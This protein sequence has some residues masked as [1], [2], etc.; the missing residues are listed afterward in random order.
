MSNVL[1]DLLGDRGV[2]VADG[3]MGTALFELGLESGGCPELLNVER[4]DLIEKVHDGYLEAGADIILTNTF[5]GNRPRLALHGLEDRVAELNEAAV[6]IARRAVSNSGRKAV[7]AGSVGPTGE[8]F[9]PIGDFDHDEGVAAFREQMDALEAAGVDV[10]WVETLSSWEELAAAIEAAADR[11]VPV[12]T[13]LSFDTNGHTMMGIPPG[14]FAEWWSDLDAAPLAL[15]ANCGVGPSDVVQAAGS[16]SAAAPGAVVV[17]KG[18]CGIP[19][20]QDEALTYPSGPSE[21]ADYAELAVRSGARIVGACCGSGFDH[22]A[23]IRAT[24][25][26]GIDGD[27]PA[28]EEIADRLGE[29]SAEPKRAGRRNAR[30]G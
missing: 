19:L 18:N 24:V 15:G 17:A 23:A 21:M 16:I 5:G 28:V 22:I 27:R 14:S 11:Q 2:L 7:V 10:L 13:T 29:V 12:V 6:R 8:L 20:F 3:A 1:T 30:R 9:Q 25:D 4:V 26:A